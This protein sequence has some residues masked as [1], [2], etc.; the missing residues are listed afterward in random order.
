FKINTDIY[1]YSVRFNENA[2]FRVM[3]YDDKQI[4]SDVIGSGSSTPYQ[5][6][7]FYMEKVLF[8]SIVL[9]SSRESK[10]D[11]LWFDYIFKSNLLNAAPDE[12]VFTYDFHEQD[13]IFGNDEFG[14]LIEDGS[15]NLKI[16]R[17]IKSDYM[18]GNLKK[19]TLKS[20]FNKNIYKGINF[21]NINDCVDGQDP[22][23]IEVLKKNFVQKI[24]SSKTIVTTKDYE[25]TI[26]DFKYTR[27]LYSRAIASNNIENTVDIYAV[28]FT[29]TRFYRM[30]EEFRI[31]LAEYMEKYKLISTNIVVKDPEYVE[32]KIEIKLS[33]KNRN[34]FD[35]EKIRSDLKTL[36]NPTEVNNVKYE[37]EMGT[38]PSKI[39]LIKSIKN[40][41][42]NVVIENVE[43]SAIGKGVKRSS[44]GYKLP[45]NAV[46]Y[47]DEININ[48][49]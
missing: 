23:D 21:E 49:V 29:N 2:T 3:A 19:A 34:T 37:Y 28:P 39:D 31:A 8:D 38:M 32:I 14:S 36:Y 5:R 48:L 18:R 13:L 41:Y 43:V 26:K 27:I 42:K 40:K 44:E 33:I 30:T 45:C 22:P 15:Q 35:I 6:I 10:N 9:S 12:D 24:N 46:I 16:I 4:S 17:M 11:Y 47:C 20:F 7:R 1:P 25:K